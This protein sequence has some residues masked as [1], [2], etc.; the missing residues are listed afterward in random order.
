MRSEGKVGKSMRVLYKFQA[1]SIVLEDDGTYRYQDGERELYRGADWRPAVS[2][3]FA[4]AEMRVMRAMRQ[5]ERE[6][7]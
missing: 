6:A 2:A 3:F 1:L 4:T 5:M 7:G